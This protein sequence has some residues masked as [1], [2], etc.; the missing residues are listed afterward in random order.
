MSF[1]D[2]VSGFFTG[3]E[4]QLKQ[5][6]GWVWVAGAGAIYLVFAFGNTGRKVHKKAGHYAGQAALYA[7]KQ[8]GELGTLAA[9]TY[10]E[11]RVGMPPH[12]KESRVPVVPV[13][14]GET[15]DGQWREAP[16]GTS[17]TAMSTFVPVEMPEKGMGFR[18]I[19]DTTKKQGASTVGSTTVGKKNPRKRSAGLPAKTSIYDDGGKSADRYTL[20]TADRSMYG[21]DKDPFHP[22]GFGQYV[23]DWEG[24]STRHLGKLIPLSALSVKAQQFVKER[25]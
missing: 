13:H 5:L 15:I 23:G 25:I 20:I 3:L 14:R 18:Y 6:P 9:R 21:F 12:P 7:A 2:D 8:S 16:R 11:R 1:S 17:S 24:G 22:Q 4:A 10:I 19:H